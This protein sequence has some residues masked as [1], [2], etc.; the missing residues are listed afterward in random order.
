[1]IELA[2][3]SLFDLMTEV[4]AACV[5][6]NLVLKKNGDA[7]MGKGI[8]LAFA[9]RWPAIPRTLGWYMQNQSVG[10]T[11][12]R[13]LGKVLHPDGEFVPHHLSF[14]DQLQDV[15][16]TH[17][18]AFPTKHD[19]RHL[20]DLDMIANNA[21]AIST[22][23]NVYGYKKV[24]MPRLGCG[25]GGLDWERVSEVLRPILDERFIIVA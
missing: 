14:T 12:P 7:V 22:A 9:Q 2:N 16:F 3:V 19:W 5:T 20:S 18:W 15:A 25:N 11:G 8:A 4:N 21:R 24:A 23:A 6:T 10:Y 1:M 17:V 13:L